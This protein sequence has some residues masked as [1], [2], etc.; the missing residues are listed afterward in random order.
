MDVNN[1]FLNIHKQID[2]QHIFKII[3]RIYFVRFLNRTLDLISNMK[4][5]IANG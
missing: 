1:F 5:L 2:N 3:Q 4:I